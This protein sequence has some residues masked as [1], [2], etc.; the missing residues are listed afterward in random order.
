MVQ[1]WHAKLES[2]APGAFPNFPA[3]QGKQDTSPSPLKL[4]AAHAVQEGE[5]LEDHVPA[6]QVM[7]KLREVLL[8]RGL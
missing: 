7:Q 5:P 8:L 3:G 1:F 6:G 2:T 4:P